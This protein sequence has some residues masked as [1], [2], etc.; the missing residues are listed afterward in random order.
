MPY[1]A[2]TQVPVDRTRAE[3]E[4]LLAKRTTPRAT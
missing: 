2:K 1:A 4:A 3:I